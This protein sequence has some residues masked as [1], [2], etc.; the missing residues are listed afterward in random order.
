M[1]RECLLCDTCQVSSIRCQVSGVRYQVSSVKCQVSGVRCLVSS[2]KC[3]G[4]GRREGNGYGGKGGRIFFC[5]SQTG[6][7][8][9]HSLID[10]NTDICQSVSESKRNLSRCCETVAV[11]ENDSLFYMSIFVGCKGM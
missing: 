11:S 6:L 8:I 7:P 2:V 4:G 1:L 3:G 9:F 5:K 10:L